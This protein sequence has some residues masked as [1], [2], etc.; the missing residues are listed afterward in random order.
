MKTL[1]VIRLETKLA[2]WNT[3]GFSQFLKDLQD[4]KGIES[5]ILFASEVVRKKYVNRIK[6]ITSS[7][8]LKQGE[9]G[10]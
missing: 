7:G 6:E 3:P 2:L 1:E 5:D 10:L 4:Y 8:G 9:L